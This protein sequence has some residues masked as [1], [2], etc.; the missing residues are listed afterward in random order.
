MPHSLVCSWY[1]AFFAETDTTVGLGHFAH[2]FLHRHTFTAWQSSPV[3]SSSPCHLPCLLFSL[4]LGCTG[5]REDHPCGCDVAAVQ[6]VSRRCS[7]R[8]AY[9]G[10]Q[11]FRK[12]AWHHNIVQEHSSAL[13]GISV[14]SHAT[15]QCCKQLALAA[16][17]MRDAW[18]NHV[19]SMCHAGHKDQHH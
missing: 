19:A 17:S 4:S 13:Q 15:S 6:G 5:S 11:R 1:I 2:A 16:N 18:H 10:F 8:R 3:N 9:N 14:T 12:R 7:G